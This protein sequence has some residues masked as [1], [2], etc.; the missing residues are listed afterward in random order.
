[1][2]QFEVALAALLPGKT[3]A[4]AT[5]LVARMRLIKD[6]YEIAALR[7]AAAISAASFRDVLH[8]LK[9]G[10]NDL[11]VAGLM[12][13]AWKRS[14]SPRAA[15]TPI[16]S[17]GPAA[18]SLFT[19][20]AETYNA[21]DR[22]MQEGELVFIDYGAAEYRMYTSDVC[23]T[24]PVSGKFTEGQ[25]RYYEIVLEAQDSAI[26]AVRPGATMLRAI[27]AAAASGA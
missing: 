5:P 13:Y 9:P 11:E 7:R 10:M 16:V 15:F 23:R 22:A 1:M 14:G 20:K 17:S 24:Y 21:T 25:R 2:Q 4:D 18:V 6:D 12:E 19:L 3:I 8:A 26:Q 27:R